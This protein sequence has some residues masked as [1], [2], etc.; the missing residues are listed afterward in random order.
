LRSKKTLKFILFFSFLGILTTIY[1]TQIHFSSQSTFCDF[2]DKF[3]CSTVSN[4]SYSTV[5]DIPVP[6]IGL[7]GYTL[8]GLISFFLIED[9]KWMKKSFW[10]KIISN[11]FLFRLSTIALVF[12][13]Y[14]T[15]AEAFIIKAFCIFCLI[16]QVLLMLIFVFSWRLKKKN[17]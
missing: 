16:S 3:S 12:S 17:K 15:Y 9:K 4:S 14:L 1:L 11:K 8:I 13:L 5:F 10:K 6:I 7:L 2:D